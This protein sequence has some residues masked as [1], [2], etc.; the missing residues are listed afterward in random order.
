VFAL[1]LELAR[2]NGLLSGRLVGVDSTML[3][4]NAAMKTIVRRDTKEDWREYVGRLAAEAGVEAKDDADLRRFDR[5]RKGKTTSNDDWASPSDPDARIAKMKDGTT[6]LAYKAEHAVDLE[7]GVVVEARIHAADESDAAT[8]PDAL[9]GAQANAAAAGCEGLIDAAV[10]D[11][12][13]HK[14]ETLA[15]IEEF[16]LGTRTYVCEA[17]HAKPRRWEDKPSAWREATV[18]NRRRL[19][20]GRNRAL[21]RLRSERV[22]R[23][24]AHVCE[25]GGM[26]RTWIRGLVEVGKRYAVQVAAFNLGVILRKLV[27][28]GTPRGLAALRWAL[29]VLWE[30]LVAAARESDAS[31]V[32]PAHERMTASCAA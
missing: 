3:E 5:D 8:L 21:Q 20:S 9:L 13:Y 11:K 16:G 27:G 23:T 28:A 15:A 12:G 26:R 4:A 6:H 18:R 22:E 19:R 31:P 14:A 25:T 1:V 17:R 29:R 24:F 10:A 7:S 30:C 2:E 32:V